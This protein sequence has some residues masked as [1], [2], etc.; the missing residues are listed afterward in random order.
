MRSRDLSIKIYWFINHV[1]G[2]NWLILAVSVI[3]HQN[4][5][6]RDFKKHSYVIY[7]YIV[8]CN[9]ISASYMHTNV[10]SVLYFTIKANNESVATVAISIVVTFIITLVTVLITYIITSLYYKYQFKNN[11]HII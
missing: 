1:E 4:V 7:S 11:K 3:S 6:S 5:V 10:A 2:Y 8:I 9:Y